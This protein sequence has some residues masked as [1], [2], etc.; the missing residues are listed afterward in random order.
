MGYL[1]LTAK[2]PSYQKSAKRRRGRNR[3]RDDSRPALGPLLGIFSCAVKFPSA[4]GSSANWH[5]M[6][7]MF[8]HP[9]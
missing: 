3:R 1:E 9:G 2:G 7:V 8:G 5:P 6:P 4:A